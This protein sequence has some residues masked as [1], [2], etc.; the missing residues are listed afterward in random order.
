MGRLS[1]LFLSFLLVV[2][3]GFAQPGHKQSKCDCSSKAVQDSLIE[4]YLDN[5]AEKLP[6]IYNDPAW[7]SYCDSL[8]AVCPEIAYAY[9]Q[10]AIPYIKNGD[11][12]KAFALNNKAVELAPKEW[13]AYRGFLKCI[14]TKDYEGAIID[15]QKAQRLTPGGYEM[16]HTYLFY[17]GLC[18]LELGDYLKAEENLKQDIIIQTG[19]GKENEVN[20]HFNTFLYLGIVYYEMQKYSKAKEYLNKCLKAYKEL[21]EANYYLAMIYKKENNNELKGKYLQIAKESKK[22]GY[23]MNEDNLY[24]AY[25]PHQITIHEIDLE[26]GGK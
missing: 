10:K 2:C 25:Y 19:G 6:Y 24:Y 15:F 9:R 21:P 26:L 7:Q 22:E 1:I 8:L 17:E 5:G 12:E 16:D 20:A 3:I 13:T 23:S 18:N 4:R 11:Y 14:F